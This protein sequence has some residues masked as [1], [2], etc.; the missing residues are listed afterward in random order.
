MRDLGKQ[1]K[2]EGPKRNGGDGKKNAAFARVVAARFYDS[3]YGCEAKLCC[4]TGREEYG[5][6]VKTEGYW[7][8]M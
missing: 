2:E 7:R 1:G 3:S 4:E 6:D 5:C 8:M